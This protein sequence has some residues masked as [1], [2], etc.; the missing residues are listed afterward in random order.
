MLDCLIDKVLVSEEE[1]AEI[2]QRIAVEVNRDYA[3]D[4][5]NLIL[6]SVLKGS[7]PFTTDLM[8]KI[9]VVNEV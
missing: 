5:K 8:K 9:D 1:I 2:V 3:G 4:D 6:V 7:M